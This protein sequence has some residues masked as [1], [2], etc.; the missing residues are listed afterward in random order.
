MQLNVLFLDKNQAIETCSTGEQK[1][2]LLTLIFA[3]MQFKEYVKGIPTILLL[4]E[5]IAHLD[6]VKKNLLF[7]YIKDMDINCIMTG[8]RLD[9][10]KILRD[11]A[12]FF[13]VKN[14]TI[15]P[16]II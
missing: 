3:S 2:S 15:T 10:F 9:E 7:D 12:E 16:K 6:E 4:D 14:S 13:E 11:V 1:A 8:I 5:I